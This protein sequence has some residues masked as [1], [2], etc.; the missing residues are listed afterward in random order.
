MKLS[1]QSIPAPATV[2]H[3]VAED[4]YGLVSGVLFAA[5]GIAMLKAV[6][7]SLVTLLSIS[8]PT[9]ISAGAVA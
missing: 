9:Y 3:T 8:R 2:P 6:K 4:A 7:S 1:P 5:V